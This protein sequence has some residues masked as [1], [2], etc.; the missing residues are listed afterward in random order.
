M[1]FVFALLNLVALSSTSAQQLWFL[2]TD[3]DTKLE[4]L[5]EQTCHQNGLIYHTLH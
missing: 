1:R 3:D 4:A 5:A 2:V